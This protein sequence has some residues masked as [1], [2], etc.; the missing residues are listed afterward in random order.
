M[1]SGKGL[2]D[3][4]ITRPEESY[5]LCRVVV[6]DLETSKEEAKSPLRAVNTNPQVV[7]PR[8]RKNYNAGLVVSCFCSNLVPSEFQMKCP[9]HTA[10]NVYNLAR[11]SHTVP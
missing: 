1:L 2:C 9:F 5:R 4:L 6:C 10:S 3:K 8:E 7:T 11:Y